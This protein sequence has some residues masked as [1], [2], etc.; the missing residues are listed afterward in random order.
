MP[1]DPL[2]LP[3]FTISIISLLIGLAALI[4]QI[5]T[6]TRGAHRVVVSV[7][8]NMEIVGGGSRITAYLQIVIRNRGAAAVQVQSWEIL[9]PD[10]NALSV[11]PGGLLSSPVLPCMLEAGTSA[12]F[13][14]P[15]NSIAEAAG[16]RDLKAARAIVHLSTGQRILGKKGEISVH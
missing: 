3:A 2:A 14:V 1:S 5:A 15:A 11:D 16:S 7:N 12:S 9:L 13:Y 8:S 6:R 10:G 4:W